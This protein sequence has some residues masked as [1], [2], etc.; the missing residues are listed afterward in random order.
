MHRVVISPFPAVMIALLVATSAM[1]QGSTLSIPDQIGAP[2]NGDDFQIETAPSE[3]REK[4][5]VDQTNGG[6]DLCDPSVSDAERARAGVDCESEISV[7]GDDGDGGIASDPL[8]APR[9]D[10]LKD[11][12]KSLDLGDDVPATIILQQ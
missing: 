7:N 2:S 8:L 4:T 11:E 6:R 12:L 1:A 9:A 3:P 5:M 10:D